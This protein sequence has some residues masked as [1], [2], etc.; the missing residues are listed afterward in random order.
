MKISF[1]V[2]DAWFQA[3]RQ[4]SHHKDQ[5]YSC[6][7]GSMKRMIMAFEML[8][9]SKIAHVDSCKVLLFVFI[10]DVIVQLSDFNAPHL[11]VYS[12]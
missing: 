4:A 8:S 12:Y 1:V 2:R 10:V 9:I 5:E 3:L 6:H 7:S 11:K